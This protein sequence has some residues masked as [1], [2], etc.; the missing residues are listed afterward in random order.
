MKNWNCD[1][2]Y[3]SVMSEAFVNCTSLRTVIADNVKFNNSND[4]LNLFSGCSSLETIQGIE[5]WNTSKITS[6]NGTFENCRSLKEVDI[7]NWDLSKVTSMNSM[8][9][10]CINITRVIMPT[11]TPSLTTVS[12]MFHSCQS[13]LE[14]P[15]FNTSK[16]THFGGNASGMC[17][18]C[19]SITSFPDFD[20]SSAKYVTRIIGNC[21][22]LRTIN[23]TNMPNG[24][25][26]NDNYGNG[27][28]TGDGCR[29]LVEINGLNLTDC[30]M[31]NPTLLGGVTSLE[32]LNVIG[33][34]NVSFII[35]RAN[36]LSIQSLVN[37]F[38]CL[39]DRNGQSQLTV[40][41]GSTN[42]AK[43]SS[44]QIA[45]ATNKNWTVV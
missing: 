39:S 37:L 12:S 44:S 3:S 29:Q 17:Q 19:S 38:N 8:F 1:G 40:N 15:F 14:I 5:T 33:T 4:I 21:N 41:I 24:V 6:T 32:N 18:G 26:L 36:K 30:T 13:L 20:Y 45:I 31:G 23:F 43:L 22:N 9:K 16:V 34:M 2:K 27:S 7:S 35:D 25:N 28:I 10:N 11:N 42:I